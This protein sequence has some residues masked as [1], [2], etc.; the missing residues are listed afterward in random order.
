MKK[1]DQFH[2]LEW[3]TGKKKAGE[4]PAVQLGRKERGCI[5][6]RRER[7]KEREKEKKEKGKKRKTK[8]EIFDF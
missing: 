6:R 4:G 7:K 1:I 5:G 2:C 3:L 8:W